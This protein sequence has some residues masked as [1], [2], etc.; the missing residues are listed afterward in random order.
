M[1][2]AARNAIR[3]AGQTVTFSG[4]GLS[5]ESGIATFREAQTGLWARYDPMS[6]AS[7]EGFA[8]DPELVVNWYNHRRRKVAA[9]SPNPAHRAMARRPDIAHVTQN[10]DDLLERAGAADVVHLHGSLSR[11]RCNGGCGF[12]EPVDLVDPPDLRECARCGAWMRPDVVWFGEQLP[13]TAWLRAD[14]LAAGAEVFVVIGTSARVFPAAGL[15]ATA[16]TAGA[17]LV[18]VDPNP[19]V[20]VG[21]RLEGPAGRIVPELLKRDRPETDAS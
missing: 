7:P 18:V 3:A 13:P 2:E 5:A 21:I 11:D 10:V 14:R 1:L 15:I 20:A 12:A 4:A 9:A 8:A 19:A 16:G 6:L 17:T